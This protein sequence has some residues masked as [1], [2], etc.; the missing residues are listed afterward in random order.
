MK[1]AIEHRIRFRLG[2]ELK[3]RNLD[4]SPMIVDHCIEGVL[5]QIEKS[6]V[7]E[8]FLRLHMYKVANAKEREMIKSMI[9]ADENLGK[10][11]TE[12]LG[13]IKRYLNY[14]NTHE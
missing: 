11:A 14:F 12:T 3:K 9:Q 5:E 2:A 10:S 6:M 4:A 1:Y 7:E 13:N 8:R